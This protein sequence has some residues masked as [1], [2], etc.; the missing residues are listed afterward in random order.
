MQGNMNI[1]IR[2]CHHRM[3]VLILKS[4]IITNVTC[5]SSEKRAECSL[6]I[7]SLSIFLIFE[8]NYRGIIDTCESRLMRRNAIKK[9]DKDVE[10]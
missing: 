8:G 6:Q 9:I 3:L 7:T 4:M 10:W 1:S 5:R 2:W